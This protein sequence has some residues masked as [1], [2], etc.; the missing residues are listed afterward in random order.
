MIEIGSEMTEIGSELCGCSK[1]L[2][3]GP[4]CLSQRHIPPKT[5]ISSPS[6]SLTLW[7][8]EVPKAPKVKRCHLASQQPS[9]HLGSKGFGFRVEAV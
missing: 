3:E 2:L 4:R 7:G 1:Q 8:S 9:M 5:P 6:G